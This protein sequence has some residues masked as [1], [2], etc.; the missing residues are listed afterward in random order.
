MIITTEPKHYPDA[1]LQEVANRHDSATAAMDTLAA[2]LDTIPLLCAEI[3][4]LR[5]PARPHPDRPAQPDRRRPGHPRR[6]RGRR[7]RPALLPARRTRRP[8]PPSAR[9]PG[10]AMTSRP[11]RH[12]LRRH[13]RRLRRDGF[14]PMMVINPGDRL[15]ETACRGH[16]PR[17]LALPLRTRPHR[18][19]RAHRDHSRGAAP[20]PPPIVAL[21]GRSARWPA[22][23]LR[24]PLRRPGCGRHGPC[25]TG[26]PNASTP[27][28]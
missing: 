6:P 5:D 2:A 16:R 1:D 21:A 13:A 7:T 9:A 23:R 20:R 27:A 14:Q 26:P 8:R 10:A 3:S 4:R 12:Q 11:T 17:D 25:W 15:P 22:R 19:R 18:R 28:P 24:P